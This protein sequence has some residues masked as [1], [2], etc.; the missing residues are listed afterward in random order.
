MKSHKVK[1]SNNQTLL[2]NNYIPNA[3]VNTCFV[4]PCAICTTMGSS[5]SSILIPKNFVVYEIMKEF[6][7][8]ES[9]RQQTPLSLIIQFTFNKLEILH[10]ALTLAL[11]PP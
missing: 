11:S 6:I 8:H 3:I 10:M 7:G 2:M 9:K 1:F 4:A 5:T